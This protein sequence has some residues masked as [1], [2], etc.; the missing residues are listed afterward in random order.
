[1]T[2]YYTLIFG[3]L[4]AEMTMFILLMLPVPSKYRRPVTLALV[5]PFEQPQIQ[6]AVKCV[7]VFILLLFV[8]TINRVYKIESELNVNPVAASGSDRAEV[9]SRKFYAQRNMYLTGITLFLTFTV[10]RTFHLVSELLTSK[11]VYRADPAD[12]NQI[13]KEIAGID[14]EIASLKER[15][16][17]LQADM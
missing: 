4:V 14:A 16:E 6:V 5:K 1:M 13:K 17:S 8:D 12:K 3:V 15:A 9:L 7:L 10:F 11:E 2:L